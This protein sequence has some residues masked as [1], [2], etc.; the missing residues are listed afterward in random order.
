MYIPLM[1]FVSKLNT[2]ITPKTRYLPIPDDDLEMLLMDLAD[3]DYTFFSITDGKVVEVVKVSSLCGKIVL[4]RGAEDTEPLVL[5]CG[6]VV[7]FIGTKTGVEDTV[8]QMESCTGGLA[9]MYEQFAG[10]KSELTATYADVDTDL[11]IHEQHLA[12]LAKR[13]GKDKHTYLK[14]SD[15]TNIEFIQVLGT[16]DGIT[17]KRGQEH[18]EAV[19]FPRGTC[20]SWELTQAAVR[21][22]VCQMDCCP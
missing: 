3:E 17:V 11:P 15:G 2:H 1:G 14:L 20:V 21:E 13:L 7:A 18:T 9:D 6:S 19:T 16:K 22:I 4:D 8:C 10:F 5:R 12:A